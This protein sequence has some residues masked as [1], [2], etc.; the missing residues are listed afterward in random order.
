VIPFAMGG[1]DKIENLRLTCRNHNARLSVEW[2]G[3]RRSG[4]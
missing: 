4:S 1:S 2:F 3:P